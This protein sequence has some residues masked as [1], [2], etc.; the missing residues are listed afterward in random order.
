LKIHIPA[1]QQAQYKATQAYSTLKNR[2]D[3]KK[4]LL[5][6]LKTVSKKLLKSNNANGHTPYG[7]KKGNA[8]HVKQG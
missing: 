4:Q 2:L 7:Q 1:T 8:G 5:L 6:T 3:S